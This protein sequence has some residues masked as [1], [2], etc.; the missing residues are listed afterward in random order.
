MIETVFLAGISNESSSCKSVEYRI[1]MG[2]SD[3]V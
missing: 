1:S 2:V 3:E